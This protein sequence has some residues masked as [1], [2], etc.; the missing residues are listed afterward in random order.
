MMIEQPFFYGGNKQIEKKSRLDK[1]R[2]HPSY[3][4][5]FLKH[6]I[7]LKVVNNQPHSKRKLIVTNS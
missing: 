2:N 4:V 7:R 5:I 6:K 1:K 3:V